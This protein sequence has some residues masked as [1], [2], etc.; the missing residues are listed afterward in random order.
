[1]KTA[2]AAA[3]LAAFVFTSSA[4][5]ARRSQKR[6]SQQD[7][8]YDISGSLQNILD[9]TH[10]SDLYTYPTDLT[11]GIVPV[12]QSSYHTTYN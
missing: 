10:S 9:N 4:N 12:S 6:Q 3:A 11:R 1:M 8:S 5:P 7:L 2:F